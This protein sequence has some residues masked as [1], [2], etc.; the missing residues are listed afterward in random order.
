MPAIEST[1]TS[2]ALHP[3]NRYGIQIAGVWYNGFGK[4]PCEEGDM[5]HVTY[6]EKS[7]DGRVFMNVEQCTVLS[8]SA[9]KQFQASL[10]D[11]PVS[12]NPLERVKDPLLR[13]VALKC[14]VNV[15]V[16]LKPSVIDVEGI[17]GCAKRFERFLNFDESVLC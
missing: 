4:P 10:Q 9:P 5:V 15:F 13:S 6:V 8:K 16:G 2:I 7:K 17:I 3:G 1:V 12:P 11:S 14:A